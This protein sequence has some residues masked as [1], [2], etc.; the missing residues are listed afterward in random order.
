MK[1]ASMDPAIQ[2]TSSSSPRKSPPWGEQ[3]AKVGSSSRFYR[4][5]KAETKKI[6]GQ[7]YLQGHIHIYVG[8][9]IGVEE[10]PNFWRPVDMYRRLRGEPTERAKLLL[11]SQAGSGPSWP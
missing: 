6:R 1:P 3:L 9:T 5:R 11:V 2:G 4:P 7:Y 10:F 8:Q